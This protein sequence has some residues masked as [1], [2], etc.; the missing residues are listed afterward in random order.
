MTPDKVETRLGTLNFVDGVPTVQATQF[1]TPRWMCFDAKKFGV[2][3]PKDS[4]TTI[5]ERAI[6]SPIWFNPSK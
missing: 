3:I 6:T 4:P 2:P 1:P 5:Q